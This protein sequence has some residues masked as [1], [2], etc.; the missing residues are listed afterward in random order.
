MVIFDE[1]DG[2]TI[3][4]NFGGERSLAFRVGDFVK[5]KAD[6]PDR[7]LIKEVVALAG[8]GYE[9]RYEIRDPRTGKPEGEATLQVPGRAAAQAPFLHPVGATPA[10][11]AGPD[12]TGAAPGAATSG[13]GTSAP[14]GP[15]VETAGA[16]DGEQAGPGTPAVIE[17]ASKPADDLTLEDLR[18][19][20]EWDTRDPRRSRL[21]VKFDDNTYRYFRERDPESLA[22][23]VRTAVKKDATGRILGLEI[24]G[25]T[26]KAPAQVL[27]VQ[28][29]DILVSINGRRVES[30][31]DVI[32]IAKGV[33]EDSL[34]TVVIDRHGKIF[35][36]IVDPRDPH[37][38]RAVRYFDEFRDR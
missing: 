6:D 19:V 11:A 18:P 16:S 2:S 29:G 22:K 32:S 4:F 30:E 31:A 10:P 9:I 20:V 14:G 7:F 37:T 8:G 3:L 17:S 21:A 35:T 15:A 36:Y 5:Q 13:T 26:D 34:V 25:F 23:T 1:D 33:S 24:R 27:R 38:R 12:G 28:P